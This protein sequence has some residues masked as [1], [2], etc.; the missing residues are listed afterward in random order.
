MDS[1]RFELPKETMRHPIRQQLLILAIVLAFSGFAGGASASVPVT[2][3]AVSTTAAEAEH[4]SDPAVIA[5]AEDPPSPDP[6]PTVSTPSLPPVRASAKG[7]DIEVSNVSAYPNRVQGKIVVQFNDD[8]NQVYGCSGTMVNSVQKNVVFTAG[9]CVY[10]H[11]T[12]AFPSAMIFVPAYQNGMEPYGEYAAVSVNSPVGWITNRSFS[13]DM[14]VVQLA[15][16]PED[17]IGSRGIA[18][19]LNPVNRRFHIFGYPAEPEPDYDGEKLIRCDST[20]MGRDLAMGLRDP[21]APE[22]LSAGPCFMRQ[23]ASGGGWITG[24]GYLN[25][26]T[27]YVYCDPED[28]DPA[29][30]G[31][32][33][34]PYFSAAAKSLYESVADTVTPTVRFT[35]SP[36]K[37]T[38]KRNLVVR[39]GGTGTTPLTRFS[40]SLDSSSWARCYRSTRLSRLSYGRH[41]LSVVSIDQTG[42]K[43]GRTA[44]KTFRVR[45]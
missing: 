26:L 3:S 34:G 29:Y 30:C 45:R 19:D 11:D 7:T 9:H 8:P 43:S 25:S 20:M 14:G 36:P 35:K 42:R 16:M 15:G 10:D 38:R 32:D 17:V 27:S 22:P 13:Y 18:F 21:G 2:G 33:F 37:V 40:C 6:V 39:L 12:L 5:T 1:T 44:T 41:V 24:G 23:G 28:Q 4:L 31:L